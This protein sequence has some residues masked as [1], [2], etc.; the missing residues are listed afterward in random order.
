MVRQ[1]V[2]TLSKLG[3]S[4]SAKIA[5]KLFTKES[6]TVARKLNAYRI[7]RRWLV[8]NRES[9]RKKYGNQYVA[10]YNREICK[11]YLDHSKLLEY[12]KKQYKGN[13][14]AVVIDYIGKR[15][16]KFLL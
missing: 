14:Q 7:N 2:V 11:A 15:K 8:A 13:R 10:V 9:Y 6:P 3:N 1:T 5:K 12:V 16:V 4:P